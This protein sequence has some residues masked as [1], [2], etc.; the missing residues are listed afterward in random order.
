MRSAQQV[1]AAGGA[2]SKPVGCPEVAGISQSPAAIRAKTPLHEE[3]SVLDFRITVRLH[4]R[5]DVSARA[6]SE[7][8]GRMPLVPSESTATLFS[9]EYVQRIDR[10]ENV[11]VRIVVE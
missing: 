1:K 2:R 9:C 6:S 5:S 8:C 10:A 4:N 3:L 11:D 7:R